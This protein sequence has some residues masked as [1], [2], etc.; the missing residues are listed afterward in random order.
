M[1][2]YLMILNYNLSVYNCMV[3][4]LEHFNKQTKEIK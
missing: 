3:K 4:S 1:I 2:Y